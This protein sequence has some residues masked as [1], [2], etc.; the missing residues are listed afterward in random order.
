MWD[1]LDRANRVRQTAN[2]LRDLGHEDL[3][4]ELEEREADGG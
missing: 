4:D 3:A 2:R 1:L